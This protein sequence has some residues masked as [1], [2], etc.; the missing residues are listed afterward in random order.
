M[1]SATANT[2]TES[3]KSTDVTKIDQTYKG[4]FI[5]PRGFIQLIVVKK[6]IAPNSDENPAACN[7]KIR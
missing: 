4:M 1:V 6:F 7:E 5:H 2:G 3:N